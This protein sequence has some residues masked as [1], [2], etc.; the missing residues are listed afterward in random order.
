MQHDQSPRKL[1]SFEFTGLCIVG[2]L[3]VCNLTVFYDLFHYLQ[4]L[5]VP[6]ELRGLVIGAYSLTAML[7]YLTVSPFVNAAN[8]P[9]VM[10]LGMAILAACGLAYL[11]VHSL[12]GLLALRILGGTGQFFMGAGTMAMFVA[13]IPQERSGHAFGIYSIAM[14]AAYGVVP[15]LMDAI[16]PL[17]KSPPHGYAAATL[18]LI[19]AA[20]IT[21][22][23]RRRHRR[24]LEQAEQIVRQLTWTDIRANIT[25]LPIALLILLNMIYF[26]NWSSLFFLFKGFAHEQQLG[27]VGSFFSAQMGTMVVIRLLAGR[28]F[29]MVDKTKLVMG[30]FLTVAGGYL[31]LNHLPGVWAV[32]LV[33]MLFGAGMGAG[34]PAING[35]MFQ[36]SPQRFRSLNANL[37]MF[38]VQAGFFV[39]PVIGGALVAHSHYSGY[40]NASIALSI[41]AALAGCMLLARSSISAG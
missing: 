24:R 32:P 40:F 17:I 33:G 29:D 10:L 3:A 31:A 2:F 20:C 18:S 39:G 15:T 26:A 25:K 28:L 41:T 23:V 13:V 11:G 30:S 37:M 5:G 34:Y 1:L 35:L 22:Q 8:A 4:M 27:N 14:L 38:A 21:V 12:P 19:P 36:L 6:A 7:L 9:R 16:A